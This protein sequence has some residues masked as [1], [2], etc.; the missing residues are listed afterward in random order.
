MRRI[1]A[2]EL[3]L[4]S[5]VALALA[6]LIALIGG[7]IYVVR[8]KYALND[9]TM[10]IGLQLNAA[11]LVNAH[12]THTDEENAVIAEHEGQ[13]AVIAPENYR[14]LQACL[15]R[16]A[17]MPFMGRVEHEGALHISV[18]GASDLY[19]QPDEDGEGFT[20]EFDTGAKRYVMHASGGSHWQRLV[21]LCLEGST[22]TPNIP[23]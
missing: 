20:V 21:R 19:V 16:Q 14:A 2:G 22:K 9:Y 1:R 23:L 15:L 11:M 7:M 5:V 4:R 8:A 13:R 6:A 12:Q 10:Q 17:A 3:V 18:C